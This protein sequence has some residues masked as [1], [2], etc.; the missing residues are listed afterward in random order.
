LGRQFL[1]TIEEIK[2]QVGNV[3]SIKLENGEYA[4]G[5]TIKK[6]DLGHVVEV[7]DFVGPSKDDYKIA[8]DKKRLFHPQVIDSRS[9]FWLGKE[10]TWEV[11]ELG[12][13][14][15]IAPDEKEIKFVFGIKGDQKLVDIFGNEEPVDDEKAKNHFR[16]IPYGDFD[17]RRLIKFWRAKKQS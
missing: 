7:F 10:G 3:F 5:R 15:F 8:V 13:Q 12:S 14:D 9:I 4:F 16:Y 2:L 1:K 17:I 6:V 11:L